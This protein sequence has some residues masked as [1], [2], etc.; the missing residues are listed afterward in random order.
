MVQL[1]PVFSDIGDAQLKKK[2]YE[3]WKDMF[4]RSQWDSLEDIPFADDIRDRSLVEHINASTEAAL[5]TARVFEQIHNV[6]YETDIIIVLGLLHDCS[7]IV[8]TEPSE[9]GGIKKSPIGNYIQHGAYGAMVASEHGMPVE[10]AHLIMTH[11]H[12]FSVMRPMVYLK[13]AHL[14]CSIDFCDADVMNIASGKDSI[15]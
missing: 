3:V 11:T 1:F 4:E 12:L 8:E 7:K 10:I 9:D 14:F 15:L 5:A 2:T 13:E 6:P